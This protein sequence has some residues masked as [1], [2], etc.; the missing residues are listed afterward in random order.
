MGKLKKGVYI[1]DGM[2][3]I[4]SDIKAIKSSYHTYSFTNKIVLPQ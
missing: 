1:P 4:F 3:K 2:V